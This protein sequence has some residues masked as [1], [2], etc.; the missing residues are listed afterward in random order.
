MVHISC[1][2][3][4]YSKALC[5]RCLN[6]TEV[7]AGLYFGP[8]TFGAYFLLH[9]N[10]TPI[11]KPCDLILDFRFFSCETVYVETS[12][13]LSHL[14]CTIQTLL[15][16]SVGYSL[17]SLCEIPIHSPRLND[18]SISKKVS[19]SFCAIIP[20][21]AGA[22]VHTDGKALS[23]FQDRLLAFPPLQCLLW[24]KLC[25]HASFPRCL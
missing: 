11:W 10:L 15:L 9:Q 17:V 2:D 23:F 13:E 18:L 7:A 4:I 21:W 1:S 19:V 12:E 22:S 6:S 8:K 24:R 20:P 25:C 5:P 16:H 14:H 3:C